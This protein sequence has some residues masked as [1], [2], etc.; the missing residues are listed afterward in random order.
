VVPL[1]PSLRNFALNQYQQKFTDY[2]VI[3]VTEKSAAVKSHRKLVGYLWKSVDCHWK[4][5]YFFLKRAK[6]HWFSVRSSL[7]FQWHD[8]YDELNQ[9]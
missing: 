3:T 6:F 1:F 4:P 9:M 5:V 8:G 2:H 7:D